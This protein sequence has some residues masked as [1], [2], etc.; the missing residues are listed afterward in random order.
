M[1]D[2][3]LIRRALR[4]PPRPMLAASALRD[5]RP[6]LKRRQRRRRALLGATGA[7]VLSGSAAALALSTPPNETT[8]R[9]SGVPSVPDDADAPTS[10]ETSPSTSIETEDAM[11]APVVDA[12]DPTG[13]EVSATPTPGISPQP[14]QPEPERERERDTVTVPTA[15]AVTVPA[16]TAAP[17]PP[18]TT[19]A[20]PVTETLVSDCGTVTV[21]I[22]ER[23]A[24]ILS[25]AP[26]P[27]YTASVGNDGPVSIEVKFTGPA[28]TCE[29][30]AELKQSGL[31]IEI[32]NPQSGAD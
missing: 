24:S 14:D 16:T 21:V 31:D 28:G 26:V 11:P 3:D 19:A 18:P 22:Q 23:T 17:A 1:N 27:G 12:A 5:L 2:D 32:Q 30:H 7:L 4:P 8:L 13:A 20:S 9:I 10:V 6:T 25:V 29:L 15:P